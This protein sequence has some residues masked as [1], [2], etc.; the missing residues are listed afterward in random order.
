MQDDI[1]LIIE[2]ERFNWTISFKVR[3]CKIAILLTLLL[4]LNRLNYLV[5]NF[6]VLEARLIDGNNA[7]KSEEN[8]LSYIK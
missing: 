5:S 4:D 6:F 7:S 3:W 2:Y 8:I 1:T